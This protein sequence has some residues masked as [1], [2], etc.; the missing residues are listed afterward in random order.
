MSM[1]GDRRPGDRRR[2]DVLPDRVA[3]AAVDEQEALALEGLRAGRTSHARVSAEIAVR[4]HSIARRASTLNDSI[5]RPPSA[6]RVV[7]AADAR[8][9]RCRAGGR[10]PRRA[11]ARSPRR[12][13]AARPRRPTGPPRAPRRGPARLAWM[14][15][16]TATRI[17]GRVA[18]GPCS[19]RAAGAA[20][21][22]RAGTG[23]RSARRA[24]TSTRRWS[25]E[26]GTPRGID[27]DRPA[28]RAPQRPAPRRRAPRS[29]RL[30]LPRDEDATRRE[31]RQGELHELGEGRDGA[32]R[33]ARA[34]RRGRAGR[35]RAASA[36]SA[37]AATRPREAGRVGSPSRG[38]GPSCR[39]SRRAAPAP[40]PSA[41]ASGMPGKPPPEPRS[42]SRLMPRA[43][44]CGAAASESST[45]RR[46][47]SAGLADRGQ[48]DRRGPR[49]Q[50]AHVRVEDR[51]R[52]G[53]Q[54]EA[55]GHGGPPRAHPRTRR[56][57]ARGPERASG[58]DL[59]GRP[60]HPP[61]VV[62]HVAREPLPA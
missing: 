60:G 49:E 36:R 14:S 40:T 18:Q 32:R 31:Q 51:A 50:Q 20:P 1:R 30:A 23:R 42:S 28:R 58:A 7:V 55:R 39:P 44:R 27:R 57:A 54:V 59:S 26:P 41:A 35:G 48:V 15:D 34:R 62:R 25:V 5:S 29:H 3:R 19:E 38:S 47:T 21:R 22:G 2:G 56:A 33:H 52:V 8:A 45:W 46:A 10:R 4:V 6:G 13:P 17:L 61:V 37:S 24:G 16:R 12:R 43:R 53:G 11:S 9:P